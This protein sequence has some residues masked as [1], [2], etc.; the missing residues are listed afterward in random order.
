MSV[1]YVTA[2]WHLGHTNVAKRREGTCKH[3]VPYQEHDE[4]ILE[5]YREVVR[6][7]DIV[8]FLGDII[9]DRKYLEV[10]ADLPGTKHL[11]LGNHD[12]APDS[13]VKDIHV[14]D[15]TKVFTHITGL[16]RYKDTWLS[17]APMHPCELRG[18]VNLHGHMHSQIVGDPCYINCCVEHTEFVPMSFQKLRPIIDAGKEYASKLYPRS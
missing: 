11:V 4:F 2:D 5:S 15:L 14:S 1:V 9:M 10:V 3:C 18:K 7:R 13:L 16:V 6:P 8:W 12:V 17:H